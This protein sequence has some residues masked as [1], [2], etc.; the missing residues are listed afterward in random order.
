MYTKAGN[1]AKKRSLALP[2]VAVLPGVSLV[3]W[4]VQ[5]LRDLENEAVFPSPS[6]Q[7]QVLRDPGLSDRWMFERAQLCYVTC[8]QWDGLQWGMSL[9]LALTPARLRFCP[10]TRSSG[11]T[12]RTEGCWVATKCQRIRA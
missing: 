5:W 10:G 7:F 4:A 2:L 12:P 3:P 1:T 9:R 6:A 8:W 11:E